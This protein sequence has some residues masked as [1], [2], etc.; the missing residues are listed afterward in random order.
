MSVEKQKKYEEELNNSK[1]LKRIGNSNLLIQPE[2]KYIK[3]YPGGVQIYVENLK[4]K[5]YKSFDIYKNYG[6]PLDL[7]EEEEI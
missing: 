6:L 5:S 7:K 1:A 3:I 4:R 2:G